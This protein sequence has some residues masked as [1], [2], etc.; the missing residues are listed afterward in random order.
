MRMLG[1]QVSSQ[2]YELAEGQDG[3][4]STIQAQ[5]RGISRHSLAK[6]V[7][8]G[9]LL[10]LSRG[11]YRLKHF[12]E[13]SANAHLWR[14][15]LWPQVRTTISGVLSHYTALRLH[16]LSD[17]NDERTHVALPPALRTKRTVPDD[18]V[19]HFENLQPHEITYADGLPTTSVARTLQDIAQMG[20]TLILR[21]AL[22][23][24]RAK[25][26]RVPLEFER[27]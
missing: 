25:K 4:F 14:A 6:A 16:G 1:S 12:P 9:K 18:I 17:I 26:L 22:R 10:R 2:L 11:V 23:D 8:R 20:D 24:A 13:I 15:V 7:A 3:Y 27:V 21:N 19:L 5:S